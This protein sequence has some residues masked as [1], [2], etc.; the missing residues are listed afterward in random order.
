MHWLLTFEDSHRY[1]PEVVN[2]AAAEAVRE[3][4]VAKTPNSGVVML[5]M[6]R[7]SNKESRET[8][9]RHGWVGTRNAMQPCSQ[10]ESRAKARCFSPQNTPWLWG[11]A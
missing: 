5:A 3:S 8:T 9:L 2:K 6:S 11:I 7:R 10:P 1:C 4:I